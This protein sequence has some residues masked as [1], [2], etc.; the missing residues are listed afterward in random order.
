MIV[1]WAFIGTDYS[2]SLRY[3]N[4]KKTIS[5]FKAEQNQVHSGE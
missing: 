2:W 4:K 3:N 5:V 1:Y